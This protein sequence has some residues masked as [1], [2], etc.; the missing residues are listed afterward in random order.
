MQS[1]SAWPVS[2]NQATHDL[3]DAVFFYTGAV[4]HKQKPLYYRKKYFLESPANKKIVLLQEKKA[5][6]SVSIAVLL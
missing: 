3:S 1:F 2:S 5:T 4:L 6:Q